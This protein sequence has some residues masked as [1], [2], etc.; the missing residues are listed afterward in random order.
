MRQSAE[1]WGGGDLYLAEPED[2][3]L[4]PEYSVVRRTTKALGDKDT[5][6]SYL[7]VV[8]S[9]TDL[10]A[11]G[12]TSSAPQLSSSKGTDLGSLV[13]GASL[14]RCDKK[15]LLS[16]MEKVAN[17]PWVGQGIFSI[18]AF[19]PVKSMP[20]SLSKM[21]DTQLEYGEKRFGN[22][23]HIVEQTLPQR[24]RHLKKFQV[25]PYSLCELTVYNGRSLVIKPEL[26]LGGGDIVVR[27]VGTANLPA[28]R[29]GYY[30][31]N[32]N[33][34]DYAKDAI[35]GSQYVPW[36]QTGETLTHALWLTN[37]PQLTTVNNNTLMW[38]A[39]NANTVAYE[40]E[41]AG[42]A[43]RRDLLSGSTAFQNAQSEINAG[44]QKTNLSIGRNLQSAWNNFGQIP[45][46]VLAAGVSGGIMD[47]AGAAISATNSAMHNVMET[48]NQNN[49]LDAAN[50]TDM[51]A[52]GKIASR[53]RELANYVANNDYARTISG[54]LARV[55]DSRIQSPTLGAMAGGDTLNFDRRIGITAVFKMPPAG[56]IR[57]IGEYW[58]RYGYAANFW[59]DIQ[60]LQPMS[61]FCYWKCQDVT[62]ES[63]SCPELYRKVLRGIL[64][65]GVTVWSDPAHI[66]K[67]DPAVNRG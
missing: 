9:T 43:K 57:T 27:G 54:I 62:L 59:L 51:A 2:L 42:Y 22:I 34:H 25:F 45:G 47:G 39:Q 16:L 11:P 35:V 29:V 13:Q 36:S 55:N 1:E 24:Y 21:S 66:G 14:Y 6:D 10:E 67:I 46:Q 30:V 40:R 15:G 38:A 8:A 32:Y 53:N 49:Y 37:L 17:Q 61:H 5:F 28:P 18:T 7:Y 12:G 50:Q 48:A 56:V 4:G 41:L 44:F 3:D 33:I 58:L 20:T 31:V 63:Y 52:S 65:Q 19:P 64:E 60:N 23:R 26:L